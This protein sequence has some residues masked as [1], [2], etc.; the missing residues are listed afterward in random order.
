MKDKDRYELLSWSEESGR[1]VGE[2]GDLVKLYQDMID[3]KVTGI[4]TSQNESAYRVY[5]DEMNWK[6]IK[7]VLKT[8]S[9][10]DLCLPEEDV[11]DLEF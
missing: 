5:A 7:D 4:W 10:W 6:I 2:T 3:Q 8:P 11:L 9:F 1:H